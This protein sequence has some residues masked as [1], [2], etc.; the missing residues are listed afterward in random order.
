EDHPSRNHHIHAIKTALINQLGPEGASVKAIQKVKSR[1]AFVPTNEEHAE[2][3]NGKSQTITSVLGGKAEKTEEW[4]TYV[5]DHVPRKLHSLEGKEIVVT[6]ES[7][8]K[9][10]EASTGLVPTR[11]AWSRKTLENPLPTGTI[12][13]SF[14][15]PTQIFRLFGTSFLARKIT[16]SSKPA[17]CPKSWGFHD[18][19]LCNFEQ[20]CKCA[21][22]KGPHVADEIHCPARPTANVARGQANHDLALALARA[23]PRKENHQKNPDYDTF[24]PIDNW[25]VRPRVIT[26][27]KRGRGLQ[28]TQIRPSNI[29]DICWVTILGVTPPITIANVYRP[30]QE[31]KVGSV[32][33]ALKSWQAPSNYLV[34]GDFNT[35]HSLWDFRASASRK[36]E[37]LVEWAETNGLVLASPIDE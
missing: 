16:K 26:Y 5:V 2:Q 20:R 1:I 32:M 13:A 17:Q 28:A 37:E 15:K 31:A 3:L 35:R 34:A 12:V 8:R 7:A 19:R 27:T 4:T 23:E 6:V 36:S 29:T 18:A 33:T 22:C 30:P 14:K 11:V 25:E 21:N 10:V 24:S 9:E